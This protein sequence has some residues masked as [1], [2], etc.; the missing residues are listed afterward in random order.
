MSSCYC[1]LL[2]IIFCFFLNNKAS[3]DRIKGRN[4]GLHSLSLS[5]KSDTIGMERQ[6]FFIKHHLSFRIK[7]YEKR[8]CKVQFFIFV[9]SLNNY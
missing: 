7:I 9:D 8:T 5:C 1:G 4:I 6:E 3:P 2:L